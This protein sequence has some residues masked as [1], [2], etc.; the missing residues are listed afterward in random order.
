MPAQFTVTLPD[1]GEGVVEGEVIEWLKQVGEKVAQDEPVVVVMTDKATVELPS[2]HPGVLSKQYYKPG[3]IAIKGEPLYDVELA[4]QAIDN[5]I[6]EAPKDIEIEKKV[7]RVL[8]TQKTPSVASLIREEREKALA[9]PPVRKLAKE[10]GVDINRTQ[11]SGK[12]GRVTREDL[13]MTR[14]WHPSCPLHLPDDEEKSLIG[15]QGL[16]AKKM[17]ESKRM[18]PH[19]SYHEKV[20][21]SRLVKLREKMKQEGERQGVQ[22]TYM[23]FFIRALSLTIKKFP[24]INASYE[25]D[26]GKLLLHKQ[27]NIGLAMSTER[28]LIVPVLKGVHEMSLNAIIRNYD[29]LKGNAFAGKLGKKDMQESTITISNFGVL[30]N[31]GLWATPIINYPEA[32]ILAVNKIQKQAV[33]KNE[34]L[35]AVDILNISWSFDHRFIDGDLAAKVSG[36]FSKLIKDP[37]QLL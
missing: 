26:L 6:R 27:E 37:A 12:G 34:Q 17:A 25:A 18:I 15:I 11:G 13:K 2:P 35:A 29:A 8:K 20:E 5:G 10:M 9:T 28:G 36:T 14:T 21:A 31:G 30:G 16:M 4:E 23:P 1:I 19:F 7:E 33:V 24:M 32:A 3:E 22:V